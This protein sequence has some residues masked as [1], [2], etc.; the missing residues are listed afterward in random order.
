MPCLQLRLATVPSK[1]MLTALSIEVCKLLNKPTDAML[2]ECQSS[3]VTMG[4]HP[5]AICH[6][7]SAAI[8]PQN[9]P[10]LS[11]CIGRHLMA[12]GIE[13][14]NHYIFF[15]KMEASSIGHNLELKG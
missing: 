1:D 10:D 6:L 13:K 3:K 8:T 14:T 11:S 12:F 15:H 9:K 7:Y 2:L 5:G 4:S